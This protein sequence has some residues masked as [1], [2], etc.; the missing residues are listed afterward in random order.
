MLRNATTGKI[1]SE[2]PVLCHSILSKARGLMLST[3]KTL[4][5][6]FPEPRIVP[7]HMLLVFFSIDVAYLDKHGTVLEIKRKLKPFHFHTPR[8]KASFV[9][10]T[11]AGVLSDTREGN[12]LSWD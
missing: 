8:V 2:N 4:I 1:L 6:C 3:K 9:V 7:L 5:F 11:P 10:E 12:I